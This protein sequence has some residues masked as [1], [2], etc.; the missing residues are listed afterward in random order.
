MIPHLCERAERPSLG[1]AVVVDLEA[2]RE[3][4]REY[5]AMAAAAVAAGVL[6]RFEAGCG[7]W[8]ELMA[9]LVAPFNG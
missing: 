4:R 5:R 8:S 2:Q 6:V 3:L 7:T 1:S 9:A